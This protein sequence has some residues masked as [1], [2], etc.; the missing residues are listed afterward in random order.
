MDRDRR[1]S[2]E[3]DRVPVAGR[4]WASRMANQSCCALTTRLARPSRSYRSYSS[5]N[6]LPHTCTA[7]LLLHVEQLLPG[8][9]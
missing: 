3:C 1:S 8:L 7:R 9:A 4:A 2:I 6:S 5:S